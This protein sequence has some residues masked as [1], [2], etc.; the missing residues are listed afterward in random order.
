MAL[1]PGDLPQRL[2]AFSGPA[3]ARKRSPSP[4]W[5]RLSRVGCMRIC[6][7]VALSRRVRLFAWTGLVASPAQAGPRARLSSRHFGY[8]YSRSGLY[9]VRSHWFR[10]KLATTAVGRSHM[11]DHEIFG[12]RDR[13]A[14]LPAVGHEPIDA[15]L[16]R[17]SRTKTIALPPLRAVERGIAAGLTVV[18][19]LGRTARW[20]GCTTLGLGRRVRPV[21]G[22]LLVQRSQRCPLGR[23]HRAENGI[24]SRLAPA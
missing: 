2:S 21:L 18:S 5:R 20:A 9:P 8:F 10:C 12:R 24:C 4:F 11:G 22:L 7:P 23:F 14:F 16:V 1:C 3:V 15:A 6:L 17:A 13:P 19:V